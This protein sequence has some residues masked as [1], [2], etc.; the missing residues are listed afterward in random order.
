[1]H[2]LL[3]LS[4]AI[5]LSTGVLIAQTVTGTVTDDEGTPLIGAS[6]FAK[7][8]TSGTVTDI[9]G[10]YSFNPP[11]NTELI[12]VTYT[13]FEPQ[14][15]SID[16]RSQI[17]VVLLESST[18]LDQVVVTGYGTQ[19]R[20]RLTT[21]IASV[22]AAALENVPTTT[23]EGALQGR[24]PGVTINSNAGTLGAQTSIRVRGIGSING[25]NQPLF[26]VDGIIINSDIEGSALGGPGTSPLVNINP[27]DIESIDV[28]KDA[29]SA[30]IYGS[31]G[32]NGVILITT[33]SG[34][35]NQKAV[36]SINQQIGF[37]KPTATY[38]LLSGPQYAELYNRALAVNGDPDLAPAYDDPANETNTDWLD[39]VLQ[40]GSMSET[41][42]SVRGGS[43]NL[44]YFIGATYR[45]EDGYVKS[46]NLKRYSFRLNLEQR[47]GD[48]WRVGLNLNPTRTFNQRQNEDNNVA[49]PL[50][51]RGSAASYRT[52]C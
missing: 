4:W 33:K 47:L 39:L 12:V 16:G 44:S 23:F 40:T 8:T 13:G 5:L 28:L 21:S 32:S 11:A 30:A 48:K 34:K 6:I 42:A 38:D 2:R 25:D 24:L 22:D 14:E 35:F 29:A 50:N 9:D 27:N 19:T 37:T 41:N 31:R 46:T 7:G 18:T 49:S 45:D 52:C 15:V 3:L 36:V 43:E 20:R 17:D 1:M 26:V 51:F 10:N